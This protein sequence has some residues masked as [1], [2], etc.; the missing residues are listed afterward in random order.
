MVAHLKSIPHTE[1]ASPQR[2]DASAVVPQLRGQLKDQT[3]L[4]LF[5]EQQLFPA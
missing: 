3:Y 1:P 4:M 2:T 5:S